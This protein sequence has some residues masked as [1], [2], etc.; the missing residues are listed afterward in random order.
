MFSSVFKCVHF[1][2]SFIFKTITIRDEVYK[3]THSVKKQNES[4][5][6]LFELLTEKMAIKLKSSEESGSRS[7][8]Q[9]KT[10][11]L[12]R[13]IPSDPKKDEALPSRA[14]EKA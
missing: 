7:N 13:Y 14:N 6:E 2:A 3:K 8:S 1:L 5:S 9:R 10:K 12:K 11:C 4:F